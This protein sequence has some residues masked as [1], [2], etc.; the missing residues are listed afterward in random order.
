MPLFNNFPYTNF[1]EMNL[2]WIMKKVKLIDSISTDVTDLVNRYNVMFNKV[3]D[4]DRMY[5]GFASDIQAQFNNL[6]N[7]IYQDMNEAFESFEAQM[8]NQFDQQNNLISQLNTRVQA[9]EQTIHQSYYM[10][11][12]FTGETVPVQQVI[13]ELASLHTTDA[14]T[15][16]EY[17]TADLTAAAYDALQLTAYAYDWNGKTYIN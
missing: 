9:M 11:S 7:A 8:L 3:T 6:A 15:A 13:Y 17:D 1:H 12:P 14:L 4:L 10:E 2:D 16:T 5:S